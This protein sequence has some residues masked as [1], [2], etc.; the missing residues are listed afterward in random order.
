MPTNCISNPVMMIDPDSITVSEPKPTMKSWLRQKR[1]HLTA[2]LYYRARH[3][4]LIGLELVSREYFYVGLIVLLSFWKFPG[5]L[6][7]LLMF[8]WIM[9]LW[10]IKLT[11]KRF[12]E[13]DIWLFSLIYDLLMPVIS[14]F[15]LL[16]TRFKKNN[17]FAW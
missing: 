15:L 7:I 11:M 10:I 12:K 3:R 5:Y 8:R 2:G 13:K 16:K 4:F 6:F 14:G 9:H 17:K 1:R